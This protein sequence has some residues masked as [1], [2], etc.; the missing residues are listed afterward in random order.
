MAPLLL[1]QNPMILNKAPEPYRVLF[2]LG[3]IFAVLGGFVWLSYGNPNYPYPGQQHAELMVGVFIYAFISGFLMTAIPKMTASFPATNTDVAVAAG[4]VIANGVFAL[5]GESTLFYF[6][7]AS[8]IL[9][10]MVFFAK[11][12]LAR[13]KS[14]PPFF[15]FVLLALL[16]GL[17]GALVLAFEVGGVASLIA[18]KLY[19]ETLILFLVLG[20]GSRLIPVIS[21][22]G[23]SDSK[24]P[25]EPYLNI[26]LGVLVLLSVVLQGFGYL[27]TGGL[28]KFLVVS[29]ISVF[30]WGLFKT[31]PSNSRLALGMRLSGTLVPLG[32]LLSALQPGMAIH[33]MHLTYIGGFGLMT[34]TVASRVT[35][36][37]GSYDLSFEG[38]STALWITGGLILLATATR[39]SAPFM[40]EGYISHLK[41][42]AIVWIAAVCVWSS[43]FLVRMIK[44]GELA[45]HSC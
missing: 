36:A 1:F 17:V 40:G 28:L 2:P 29:W 12:F 37:H 13:T 43:V 24:K 42:A 22:R 14:I 35:L 44:R 33:W 38:R 8:A 5:S 4:F 23:V 15:P 9:Y 6:S 25:S 32:L 19:F 3:L 39:V 27:Q 34:L 7:S 21:G 30:K 10:L 16:A 26:A 45:K 11:R 20:I 41:Y 18:R 31:A